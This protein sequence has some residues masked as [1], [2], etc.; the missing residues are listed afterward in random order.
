MANIIDLLRLASERNASDLHLVVNSP[1]MLRINGSLGPIDGM[2]PLAPEE[3]S[4]AFIQLTT[5]GSKE[6]VAD[7]YSA[8]LCGAN[9]LVNTLKY[10]DTGDRICDVN[11]THARLFFVNPLSDNILNSLFNTHPSIEKRIRRLEGIDK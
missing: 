5:S 7:E 4:E 11:P 9:V 1:P 8:R 6:Y 10:L 2:A 3:I